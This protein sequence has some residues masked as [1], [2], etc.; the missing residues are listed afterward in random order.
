MEYLITGGTDTEHCSWS[1]NKNGNENGYWELEL[2]QQLMFCDT[3][4]SVLALGLL[5]STATG[6]SLETATIITATTG[7]KGRIVAIVAVRW[8]NKWPARKRSQQEGAH[9]V[10]AVR[11]SA[12]GNWQF[13]TTETEAEHSTA[14]QSRGW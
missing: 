2:R 4:E 14:Q 9:K 3:Q 7:A 11:Q 8:I 12:I 10:A 1:G 6:Q 13:A 5:V